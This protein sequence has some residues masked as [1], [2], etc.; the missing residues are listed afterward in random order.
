MT[1]HNA[2]TR[3]CTCSSN[4]TEQSAP[5][6]R[7]AVPLPQTCSGGSVHFLAPY[8]S[9]VRPRRRLS[10]ELPSEVLAITSYFVRS[11][12]DLSSSK[13]VLNL[14]AEELSASMVSLMNG[15]VESIGSQE[16]MTTGVFFT[17]LGNATS[18]F[19]DE[20]ASL[21]TIWGS[22]NFTADSVAHAAVEGASLSVASLFS[23][24]FFA[25][26]EDKLSWVRQM[27]DVSCGA[28][29]GDLRDLC[30]LPDGRCQ[31]NA[32]DICKGNQTAEKYMTFPDWIRTTLVSMRIT[33]NATDRMR[34]GDTV[35]VMLEFDLNVRAGT[36]SVQFTGGLGE[37]QY[38]SGSGSYFLYYSLR[39][40]AGASAERVSIAE[41]ANV[42]TVVDVS[43]RSVN[44]SRFQKWTMSSG[45]RAMAVYS[46]LILKDLM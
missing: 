31:L 33:S 23:T 26:V 5:A 9:G 12:Q 25:V 10:H 2:T 24:P 8:L 30:E 14:T 38:V 36:S 22:L 45:A 7:L 28:F 4:A 20:A 13:H 3:L 11:F 18:A 34:E 17:L 21:E 39:V 6:R 37:A 16:G 42:S 44:A 15:I 27:H 41:I 43:G 40:P 29:G 1:K 35:T 19:A 46:L 32:D